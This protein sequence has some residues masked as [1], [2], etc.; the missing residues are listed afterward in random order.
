MSG[1]GA[2]NASVLLESLLQAAIGIEHDRSD[3]RAGSEAARKQ[4]FGQRRVRL[5]ERRVRVVAHAVIR[6]QEAGEEARVRGQRQRRHG[7]GL[8]EDDALARQ[9]LEM[10]KRDVHE[11]VGR[12]PIGARGIEGDHD[13]AKRR[14]HARR[15]AHPQSRE[16]ESR[17]AAG[18]MGGPHDSRWRH[19]RGV[20]VNRCVGE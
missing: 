6:R 5:L 10:R 14:G 13:D 16:R 8:I 3:E 15:D 18:E 11:A 12:Q 4:R 17:Q 2:V 9:P 1:H 20:S 19:H 7:R